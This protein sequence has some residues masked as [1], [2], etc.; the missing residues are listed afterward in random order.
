VARLVYYG[1]AA[2]VLTLALASIMA[3]EGSKGFL[4]S[5][6]LTFVVALGC[7]VA[8]EPLRRR[9]LGW[10]EGMLSPRI[11]RLRRLAGSY[12]R[13]VVELQNDDQV[14]H[15]VGDTLRAAL[16]PRGGCVFLLT[17]DEWRPAHP[18]GTHPPA[19]MVLLHQALDALAGRRLLQV[20]DPLEDP[21]DAAPSLLRRAGVEVAAA[22]DQGDTR[23]GLVLLAPSENGSPYSRLHLDF[24]ARAVN[25]AAMALHNARVASELLA[26]ERRATTGR[27]AL[28]LAHDVGKDLGLIRTLAKRLPGRL[29]DPK[30]ATRD[31]G[32]I[33]ELADELTE[34]LQGFVRDAACS[35]GDEPG[36][37]RFDHAV[38]RAV[39]SMSRIH[40]PGRITQSIEP[41]LR[42]VRVHENLERV[43]VN[44][45]DNALLASQ[46][47]D[48]VHLFATLEDGQV[49]TTV[50]DRGHGM[51]VR[52]RSQAFELG[53]TT[54]RYGGGSGVGLAVS[55]EIVAALGGT[56][57]LAPNPG[58]GTMVRARVSAAI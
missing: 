48:P 20:A 10:V 15:L 41:A 27:T 29:D 35:E 57:E 37:I 31:L 18:F 3:L 49:F 34:T 36:T 7:V 17:G 54:R 8:I 42:C 45:L 33:Q 26:S 23:L 40:G 58:G 52:E 47:S 38:A 16:V 25:H 12:A 2:A 4:E 43:L 30:R 44:L 11:E 24:V 51:S 21:M 39:R 13:R 46:K 56:I 22:L 50:S 53:Y 1:A 19:Q 6:P 5:A 55:R 14:A 9:V 32:L 28:A